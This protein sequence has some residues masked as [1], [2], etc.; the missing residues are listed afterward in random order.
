V[1]GR[2]TETWALTGREDLREFT[3]YRPQAEEIQDAYFDRRPDV[4][5]DEPLKVSQAAAVD[6][7]EKVV[8]KAN[9]RAEI[10]GSAGRCDI[11][12]R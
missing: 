3:R 8:H 10:D 6:E 5:L 1:H 2:G 12:A 9:T 7:Y 11:I 4:R